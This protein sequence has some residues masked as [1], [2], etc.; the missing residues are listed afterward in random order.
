MNIDPVILQ[1]KADLG[2][3]RRD[4]AAAERFTDARL[5]NIERRSNV[6]GAAIGKGFSLAKAAAVGFVASLGIDAV[7]GLISR[8]LEYA[9]S[10]GEVAQ[11]LGVTT[12]ALQEYRYAATQAGLSQ[13]EMD[14]ALSQLTRRIGEAADGTKA[15]AEAF[16]TLG[17]KVRDANGTIIQAGDAI[18][19][20]ADALQKVESPAA[21]AALLM[22]L[23]GRSGQKLEPLL[24]G[25]AKGINNLRDAAHELGIVLSEDQIRNAD[26]AADKLASVKKVLE[27]RIAGVVADNADAILRL[28]NALADLADKAIKAV[29]AMLKF[30]T[31]NDA[32][33][34]FIERANAN[35]DRQGLTPE[36]RAAAGAKIIQRADKR[37]GLKTTSYA[38]GGLFN[39]RT[40]NFAG[41]TLGLA[42]NSFDKM[43]SGAQGLGDPSRLA[44]LG[45]ADVAAATRAA[46]S[47]SVELQRL[48]ADLAIATADLTDNIQA[49]ADAEKQ[50][51]DAD[52]AAN[53]ERLNA[54]K[55]LKK[56]ERDQ[57]IAAQTQIAAAQK[58]AIEKRAAAD[59]AEQARRADED[60]LNLSTDALRDEAR[61]LDALARNAD[62]L[63]ERRAIEER[64]LELQQQEERARLEAAIAAGQVAD[65]AKARANLDTRQAAER[66]TLRRDFAGPL[67]RY[68]ENARDTDQ[69][70]A[71]AA[72]QRIADL[73]DTIA[74]AM[75]DALGIKD[76]F[77]SELIK[78]FLDKNIF[79]P[80][81][82][83]LD[84]KGGGGIFSAIGSVLGSLFGGKRASGGR[85][86]AGSLYRIN[87]GAGVG[88]VEGFMPDVGGTIIPLGRM[89]V[90][91]AGKVGG[92]TS[93]VRLE[94]S[95]DIDARIQRVSGP[96]ALEVVKLTSGEVINA[97]ANET[98]RRAQRPTI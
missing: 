26:E 15:Q 92:G 22:D 32:R 56:A 39:I 21:R 36:V 49:R 91:Q 48:T 20:I 59:I 87:E 10:L 78:I 67:S 79:G 45:G 97:A 38:P 73:N 13:E 41:D 29:D 83:S 33:G 14:M 58:Q 71:E 52:L 82:E 66:E 27:A 80:L 16:Q 65:A 88:R 18:P 94:L 63:A 85:V 64:I 6:A 62:T 74:D 96:V 95:G 93:V 90:A 12:D 98:M 60:R 8:S 30:K 51:V 50:R 34:A 7:T 19:Q 69:R 11:Q 75:T 23:F 54:D 5:S 81:A 9:S 68:A 47:M 84:G 61:T 40:S 24:A 37:Y 28:A 2:D 3:Y 70:V 77:L 43:L 89:N 31:A 17:I 1:L 53:V 46:S 4:M 57:Q 35:L 86:D 76:P 55:D 72:T 44:A 25:G 42:P